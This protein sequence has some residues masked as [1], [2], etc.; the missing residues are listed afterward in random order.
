MQAPEKCAT[1][2]F[3][4]FGRASENLE[5]HA[6][7][8]FAQWLSEPPDHLT[9]SSFFQP[10][11]MSQDELQQQI[12]ALHAQLEAI[13]SHSISVA[14]PHPSSEQS[15]DYQERLDTINSIQ[16]KANLASTTSA[17]RKAY[18]AGLKY[19]DGWLVPKTTS[20]NGL[21][22][23]KQ[24]QA[25]V[26]AKAG[27][28]WTRIGVICTQLKKLEPKISRYQF[29]IHHYSKALK[30]AGVDSKAIGR[31]RVKDRVQKEQQARFIQLGLKSA[32]VG[33][34]DYSLADS[35]LDDSDAEIGPFS[36]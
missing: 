4:E 1:S 10:A 18:P 31:Q 30:R 36:L 29:R 5:Q 32:I 24:K 14:L 21:A 20:N 16:R 23:L 2:Y 7:F 19:D 6:L 34:I 13:K 9:T 35:E 22:Q 27:A 8:D 26:C 33:P 12:Q 17:D 3:S 11:S 28:L 15:A 25:K